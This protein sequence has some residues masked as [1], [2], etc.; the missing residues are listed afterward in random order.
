[1][2][3]AATRV[4]GGRSPSGTGPGMNRVGAMMSMVGK[5]VRSGDIAG[6]KPV[7]G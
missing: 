6:Q 3:K 4:T 2:G 7:T 5:Y 1:M